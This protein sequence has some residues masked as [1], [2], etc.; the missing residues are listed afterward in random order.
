MRIFS[1]VLATV[2]ALLG[3]VFLAGHQGV[4]ARLVVGVVLLGG[5]IG[6]VAVTRLRPRVEQRTVVQ[7]VELSGDVRAEE[8]RCRRCGAGLDSSSV[9]VRAGAVFVACGHCGAA[10]QLEEAPKW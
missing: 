3:V 8:L 4:A 5:A 10:Y 9:E 7:R 1:Y 6:L 2:L